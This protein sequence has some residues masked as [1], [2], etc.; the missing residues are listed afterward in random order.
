M[1]LIRKNKISIFKF[2]ANN[3]GRRLVMMMGM[4][5]F[6]PNLVENFLIKEKF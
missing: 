6:S 3:F 1:L 4:T 5:T 2:S